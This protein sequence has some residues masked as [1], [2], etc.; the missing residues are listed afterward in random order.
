[1]CTKQRGK[2]QSKASMV[3]PLKKWHPTFREWCIYTPIKGQVWSKVTWFFTNTTFECSS[4]PS[5]I[6]CQFKEVIWIGG[7]ERE[8]PQYLDFST[9]LR[10]GQT[11]M[12]LANTL[13]PW[14]KIVKV[15]DNFLWWR[16]CDNGWKISLIREWKVYFQ[17]N[18]W[19]D[20]DVCRKWIDTT[21]STFVKDEKLET[22]LLVLD[23]LSCQELDEFNEKVSA[24]K[25]LCWY[26]LKAG[27]DLWQPVDSGYADVLNK[28]VG[29]Y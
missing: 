11:T 12:F 3:E 21:L 27:T 23:N 4:V 22:F 26:G 19:I 6:W 13:S 1:M 10:P 25:G 5:S 2:K 17:T 28:L 15:G 18:A 14:R 16:T 9:C 24:V 7:K 8:K 29:I 20:I